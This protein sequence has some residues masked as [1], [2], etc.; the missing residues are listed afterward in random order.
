MAPRRPGDAA[1][2]VADSSLAQRV[3]DWKPTHDSL[4]TIVQSALDWEQFLMNR[5]VDDL[6]SLHRA[7]A[8]AS[9]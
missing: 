3:L 1:R 7:L 5:N 8:A 2:V 6:Q 9:F 4:E